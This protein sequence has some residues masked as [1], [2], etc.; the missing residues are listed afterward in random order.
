MCVCVLSV[1]ARNKVN[2]IIPRNYLGTS[3]RLLLQP[4]SGSL[5][6]SMTHTIYVHMLVGI[7][8]CITECVASTVELL[9]C[10]VSAYVRIL[11]RAYT[12]LRMH[13]LKANVK[14]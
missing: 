2:Q 3:T 1:P 9:L 11:V 4:F 7:Y 14:A 12:T 6:L 5:A 13:G 8:V 10:C